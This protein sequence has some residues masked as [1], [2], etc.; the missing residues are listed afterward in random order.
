MKNSSLFENCSDPKNGED[1]FSGLLENRP[2]KFF[3]ITFSLVGG[4]L[5]LPLVYCIIWFEKF[6]SDNKRTLLN[7][8]VSSLCLTCF[9]WFLIVQMLDMIRYCFGPLPPILCLLELNLKFAI[10]T[11]QM[12]F[13]DGIIIARYIF[14]FRLKNPAAFNDDF[15]N[16]FINIWIVSYSFI[17]QIV[18]SQMPGRNSV[19]YY[20]CSGKNPLADQHI[21]AK[22]GVQQQGLSLLTILIHFVVLIKIRLYK[23]K[24]APVEKSSNF[25]KKLTIFRSIEI[26]SLS[27]LTTCICT[28]VVCSVAVILTWKANQLRIQDFNCFPNYLYEYF[29]RMAWPNMFGLTMV[30][31][32]FYRNPKLRSTVQLEIRNYFRDNMR[33]TD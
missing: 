32:Y 12:L 15:W 4:C 24:T 29:L 30:F 10:F 18:A 21:P 23:K 19:Y 6:G 11:Q 28:V 22:V 16:L 17:S 2:T 27:D 9:E 33:C 20:I 8:L 13:M 5:I 14:I 31:L 26:D 3:A 25:P 7:K 1:F